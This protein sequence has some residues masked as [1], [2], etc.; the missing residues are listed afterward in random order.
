LPPRD[1]PLAPTGQSTYERS[2]DGKLLPVVLRSAARCNAGIFD[3]EKVPAPFR[4]LP[5]QREPRGGPEERFQARAASGPG[6]LFPGT[7]S[8]HDMTRYPL[9]QAGAGRSIGRAFGASRAVSNR[10]GGM[11]C[12]QRV[13]TGRRLMRQ[14]VLRII[15]PGRF[16]SMRS[17]GFLRRGDRTG[18]RSAR[19]PGLRF[20]LPLTPESGGPSR[21]PV[22]QPAPR[23]RR[24]RRP[25]EFKNAKQN[26][27]R[28]HS[29]GRDP[30]RRGPW[31][32][33]RRV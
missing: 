30:G 10:Q 25:Q 28:C 26:V 19:R 9:P 4:I 22:A 5:C 2:A 24:A 8:R 7:V 29:P 13:Q 12:R 1:A 27:D 23:V 33:R 16:A 17:Q 18:M 6:F 15:I 21:L 32:S 3:C 20:G 14:T 31:Q 11:C